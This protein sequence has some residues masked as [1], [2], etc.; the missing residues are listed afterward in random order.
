MANPA[1][2]ALPEHY[3]AWRTSFRRHLR[4]ENKAAKTI[5]TYEGAIDA[6]GRFL[7]AEGRPTEIDRILP[8]DLEAFISDQLQRWKPYTALNSY[9]SL[10]TW[11]TWL[12]DPGNPPGEQGET[13]GGGAVACGARVLEKHFTLDRNLKG[14]DHSFSLTADLLRQ[15]IHQAQAAWQM[16]GQP[17]RGVADVEKEV[18]ESARKSVVARTSIRSGQTITAGM[19]TLKRPAGGIVPKDMHKLI[20]R[21]ARWDI[22]EDVQVVWDMVS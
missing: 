10:A 4:A 20:G 5:D 6:L 12:V 21:T 19:L 8:P 14:P 17:R 16:I 1:P 2:P 11:F 7:I 22:S 13:A 18:R 15:Y 3:V 9:R